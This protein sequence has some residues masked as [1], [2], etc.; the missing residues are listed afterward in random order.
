MRKLNQLDQIDNIT[1][2]IITPTYNRAILL[3]R[4]YNS[5]LSQ[6][7]KCFEWIII[8]DGSDDNT[9]EVVARWIDEAPFPIT[10]VL[11]ENMGKASAHNQGVVLAKGEY[12]SCL[13]SDDWFPKSAVSDRIKLMEELAKDPM[14]C[15]VVGLSV[16]PEGSVIGKRFPAAGIVGSKLEITRVASGDHSTVFKTEILKKYLFPTLPNEK[17]LPESIVYNRIYQDG[18]VFV[19]SNTIL[20][21]KDYQQSG[22]TSTHL[23]Q[24]LNSINGTILYY[25]EMSIIYTAVDFRLKSQANLVRYMLHKLSFVGF[26]IRMVLFLPAAVIGLV[27][28][29]WDISR[30]R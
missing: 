10:Y 29:L 11:Q 14:I 27:Y 5:L 2:T 12:L 18:Y 1:L 3:E 24:R 8:D 4:A 28:Y 9:S 16:N 7:A 22:L 20:G 26:S 17:F 25:H 6:E 23:E 15:G 13:D 19:S 30:R 21:V